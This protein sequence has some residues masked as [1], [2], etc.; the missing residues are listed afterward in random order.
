MKFF[1]W[2]QPAP[3][4]IDEVG[5]FDLNV[6]GATAVLIRCVNETAGEVAAGET[7][8]CYF[9]AKK[10]QNLWVLHSS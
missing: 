9:V 10:D 6:K 8:K 1:R 7:V 5:I 4:V 3:G 2:P